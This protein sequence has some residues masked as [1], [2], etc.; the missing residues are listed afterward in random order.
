MCHIVLV[1]RELVV[2]SEAHVE[3]WDVKKTIKETT[4][5]I[6]ACPRS[7]A[8]FPSAVLRRSDM[9]QLSADCWFLG[10]ALFM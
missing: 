4:G 9:W 5:D 1:M 2:L 10:F 6:L 3:A 8:D 7:C